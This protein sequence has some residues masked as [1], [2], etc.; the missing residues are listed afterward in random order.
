MQSRDESLPD[1]LLD[2]LR[3]PRTDELRED[4]GPVPFDILADE[5]SC[6]LSNCEVKLLVESNLAQAEATLCEETSMSE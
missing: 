5:D 1:R 3:R 4:S 6:G 2:F